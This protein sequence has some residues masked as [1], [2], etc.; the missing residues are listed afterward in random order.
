MNKYL[1][2]FTKVISDCKYTNTYKMAWAKSIIELSILTTQYTYDNHGR[3][4][5]S[6]KEISERCFHYYWNQT[7]FF[8]LVQGSNLNKP[9]TMIS[10]V[11]KLIAKYQKVSDNYFPL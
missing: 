1:I 4:R 10:E 11:K 5:F 3:I 6:F 8:D 9:P 2:D 7:I